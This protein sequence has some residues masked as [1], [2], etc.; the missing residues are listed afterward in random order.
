[1]NRIKWII[2]LS[3]CLSLVSA[4]TA[5][6]APT[7]VVVLPFYVESG[8]DASDGGE[9]VEHYRR[10]MRFINNQLDRHNFEV[11]NPFSKENI[12]QE[13]DRVSER[14]RMDSVLAI[15]EVCEK[16]SV[17]MAY[18]VWLKVTVESTPDGYYRAVAMLDGEG[19]DAAGHDLGVGL[20]ESMK[21]TRRDRDVAVAEV[22]KWVGDTVGR[23][24]TTWQGKQQSDT[25]G[26]SVVESGQGVLAQAAQK[27]AHSVNVRLDGATNYEVSEA[28][29]KILNT[30]TGMVEATRYGSNIVVDNPQA[31]YVAWRAN[32]A[33]TEPF[34][35]E[36]NIMNMIQQVIEADGSL[37]L[38]GVPYRYSADEIALLKG[39]QPGKANAHQLQFVVDRHV[40][41]QREMI[42]GDNKTRKGFE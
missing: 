31:S 16:Y 14:A 39:I 3:V 25:A 21:V 26:A 33:D 36:A 1:M 42:Q 8:R 4:A 10:T 22:E 30:V 12:E 19:Y 27:Y 32:I 29:G 9:A 11:I 20:S 2:I 40:M 35:L 18:I 34:R 24:L 38:K 5:F 6:A 17:D 37:T 7:R 41:M 13:Y 28:F 23:T 15:R